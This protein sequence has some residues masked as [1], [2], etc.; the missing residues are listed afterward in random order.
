MKRPGCVL[1]DSNWVA[2]QV[3]HHKAVVGGGGHIDFVMVVAPVNIVAVV[4]AAAHIDFAVVVA[5]ANID[6]VV[7]VVAVSIAVAHRVVVGASHHR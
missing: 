1:V 4:G 7:A 5:I 2:P 6:F 3:A